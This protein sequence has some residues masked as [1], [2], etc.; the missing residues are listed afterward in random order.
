MYHRRLQVVMYGLIV[1]AVFV[2]KILPVDV[3]GFAARPKLFT[4]CRQCLQV[5]L[6]NTVFYAVPGI[7]G[8]KNSFAKVGF[9]GYVVVDG[10]FN[11]FQERDGGVMGSCPVSG[12]RSA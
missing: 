12:L 10:G 3:R 9:N 1:T 2:L 7:Q 11:F 5:C 6:C 4:G 8:F